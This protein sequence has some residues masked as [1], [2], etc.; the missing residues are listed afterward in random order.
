MVAL[1][2]DSGV[3]TFA[4]SNNCA[5]YSLL[6]AVVQIDGLSIT[7]DAGLT[8]T[9]FSEAALLIQGSACIY[10]KKVEY[11]YTLVYQVLNLVTSKQ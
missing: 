10:S 6:F 3:G 1:V 7:F 11:L 8:T 9:N 2:N 5:V 4:L